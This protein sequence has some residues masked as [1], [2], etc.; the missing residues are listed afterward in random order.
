MNSAE[1]QQAVLEKLYYQRHVTCQSLAEE[2][3]VSVRTIRRDVGSLMC[4]YPIETVRGRFGGGVRVMEGHSL[5]LSQMSRNCL[6]PRQLAFLK[7]L[8]DDFGGEELE[9]LN[10]I[11]LQFAP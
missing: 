4:F 1:R 6:S 2:F 7:R 11:I 5:K 10:S 9:T 8:R 3:H